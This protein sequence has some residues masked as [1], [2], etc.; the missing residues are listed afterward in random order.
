VQLEQARIL[1]EERAKEIERLRV[2]AETAEAAA[3]G[4]QA[5]LALQAEEKK[6]AE[7]A[8]LVSCDRRN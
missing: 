3:R 7:T 6:R 5:E 1:K 8:R 2:E 4:R